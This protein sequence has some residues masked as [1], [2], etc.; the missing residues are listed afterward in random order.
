MKTR[1]SAA[2]AES[3]STSSRGR[4]AWCAPSDRA[5]PACTGSRA[6]ARI[7]C[8]S[9][10]GGYEQLADFADGAVASATLGNVARHGLD[11][12]GRVGN[13]ARQT[14]TFQRGQVVQVVADERYFV[15]GQSV[16]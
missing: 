11:R 4:P 10:S 15:Y 8:H 1:Q 7:G 3:R 14:D 16:A 6:I 12:L 13:R 2:A 5:P 9:L